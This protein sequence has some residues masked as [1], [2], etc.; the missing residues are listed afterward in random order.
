MNPLEAFG[1][2]LMQ[3][4][5]DKAILDWDK[6]IDGRMRG[7]T[8]ERVR[9]ALAECSPKEIEVLQW[10]VPQV[11]D[12]TLH[13]LLWALEQDERVKVAVETEDSV[14]ASI[15]EESDGL[16]GELYGDRGWIARFS[17]QRRTT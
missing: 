11:V 14:T 10:L 7:A 15:S 13:H 17:E 8:A 6:N 3:R 2:F 1:L 9:Q 12:T 4:V 16:P 5:R